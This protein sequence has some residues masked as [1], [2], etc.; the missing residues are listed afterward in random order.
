M[1]GQKLPEAPQRQAW[2]VALRPQS[3]SCQ[4]VGTCPTLALAVVVCF[5]GL[6]VSTSAQTYHLFDLGTLA[7]GESRPTAINTLGKV[8][9]FNAIAGNYRAFLQDGTRM[10]LG[11]LGGA[12]SYTSGLND[13][14]HVV[15]YAETVSGVEHA[16]LWSPGGMGGVPGNPQMRDLGTLGGLVS[17]AF[18]INAAGQITGYAEA[19]AD[20]RAFL[21]T[22]SAMIDIGSLTGLPNSFGYDINDLDHVAGTAYDKN[23]KRSVAFLYRDNA[24][25]DLG[26]LGGKGASAL[27]LNNS[28]EVVGY[29]EVPGGT[30]RA[31]L[32]TD[33][34]MLDLGTLGG[35]WSYALAINNEGAVVGGSFTDSANTI[36]HPFVYDQGAMLDLN[37]ELDGSGVGWDLIEAYG[38]NDAGQIVG[39][40][41]FQGYDHVFLLTPLTQL[42]PVIT[43]Q[44]NSLIVDCQSDATFEVVALGES[45]THQW[46]RGFPSSGLPLTDAST[47]TLALISVTPEDAGP[48]YVEITNAR[49]AATSSVCVLDV[50]DSTP[51][52]INGCL[53]DL[54]VNVEEGVSGAAASWLLPEA[55]DACAGTVL[56]NCQPASGSWFPLGAT[57]VNCVASDLSGNTST[58]RFTVTVSESPSPPEI[59]TQPADL[60][61]ECQSDATFEVIALG[62]SLTYQW[63]RGLPPDGSPLM[64]ASAARLVLT[65]ATPE[66]AGPYYVEV[67]NAHGATTSSVCVL[68][69]LDSAPPLITRCPSDLTVHVQTGSLGATASWPLSEATDACSGSVPVDCQPASGSWFPLGV[70]TVNCVASDPKG[71]T[72]SCNFT[73]TVS[74]SPTPPVITQLTHD[75][76]TLVLSFTTSEGSDYLVESATHSVS[77]QWQPLTLTIPG[78]GQTVTVSMP[79]VAEEVQRFYRV[80]MTMP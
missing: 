53:S 61:V 46:F 9:L 4:R 51:P 40:G 7:G 42:P 73:V 77:E 76:S 14:D 8:T 34:Q 2:S 35:D 13:S 28:D 74:E 6:M 29:S 39:L 11:T 23:Y 20:P 45:L 63:L 79:I 5:L 30:E 54:V 62:E 17:Q 75:D 37:A 57:T 32:C 47:A 33:G 50:L 27:A 71:N 48:Y 65:S 58:C 44:P 60:A 43:Q 12:Q 26:T 10:D 80:S 16:F 49:G 3:S 56:V 1:A 69:V 24:T 25:I 31:F 59:A 41:I 70:T 52:L 19:G 18:A 22:G 21:F 68:E 78:T 72:S 66:D 55:T 38:I 36:Y 67:A 15:G 64:D